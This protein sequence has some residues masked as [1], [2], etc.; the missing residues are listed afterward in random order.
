MSF[1]LNVQHYTDREDIDV[2][3]FKHLEKA[4]KRALRDLGKAPEDST[5]QPLHSVRPHTAPDICN[6]TEETS[7]AQPARSSA[8]SLDSFVDE[9][10]GHTTSSESENLDSPVEQVEITPEKW[11]VVCKILQK[12]LQQNWKPKKDS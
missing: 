7:K 4:V 5:C 10:T 11:E 8:S 3:L 9:D 1:W 12:I 6:P 2:E